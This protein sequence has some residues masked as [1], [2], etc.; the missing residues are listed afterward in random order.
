MP[1][2]IIITH[3]FLQRKIFLGL[4]WRQTSIS[5]LFCILE[6]I[7]QESDHLSRKVSNLVL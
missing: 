6:L 2:N 1:K 7:G 4:A 5:D 3:G